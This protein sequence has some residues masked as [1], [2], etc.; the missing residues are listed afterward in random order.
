MN[1][2]LF[3]EAV[4]GDM[5]GVGQVLGLSKQDVLDLI[6]DEGFCLPDWRAIQKAYGLTDSQVVEIQLS[7][8]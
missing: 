2:P 3:L 6:A 4:K 7:E 5:E 8:D 1:K